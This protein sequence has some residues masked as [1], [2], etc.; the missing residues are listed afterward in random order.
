VSDERQQAFDLIR[1]KMEDAKAFH[2][3]ALNADIFS[4]HQVDA[5]RYAMMTRKPPTR[6]QR[7]AVWWSRVRRYCSTLWLAIKGVELEE[8]SDYDY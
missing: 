8:P 2:I 4:D 3:R 6:R 5:I 1:Q 7:I